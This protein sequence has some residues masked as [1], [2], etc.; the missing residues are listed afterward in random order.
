MI[1]KT[2][3]L[4][5]ADT[6]IVFYRITGED[7]STYIIKPLCKVKK[8]YLTIKYEGVKESHVYKSE[9]GVNYLKASKREIARIKE[10]LDESISNLNDP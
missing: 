9:V 7:G 8:G 10:I 5:S 1:G 3:K 2:L 4:V 6:G